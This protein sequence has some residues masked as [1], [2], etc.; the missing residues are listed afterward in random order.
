M[1][2]ETNYEIER[3]AIEIYRNEL[4]PALEKREMFAANEIA[5]RMLQTYI[6]GLHEAISNPSVYSS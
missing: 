6:K 5:G 3:K 4:K 2:N 1:T